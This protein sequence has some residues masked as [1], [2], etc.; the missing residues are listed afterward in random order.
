MPGVWDGS[1]VS[2][3]FELIVSIGSKVIYETNLTNPPLDFGPRNVMGTYNLPITAYSGS[4][5]PLDRVRWRVLTPLTSPDASMPVASLT[6]TPSVAQ[7]IAGMGSRAYQANVEIG[8]PRAGDYVATAAF[9]DDDDDNL[10]PNGLEASATFQV[11]VSVNASYGFD[12]LASDIDFGNIDAGAS[13]TAEVGFMNTGNAA[14][15]VA[16]LNWA[17]SDIA[18]LTEPANVIPSGNLTVLSY[19]YSP[20]PPGAMATATIRL[21]VPAGQTKDVYGPSGPQRMTRGA[22]EDSCTFRVKVGG[23]DQAMV[24]KHSLYQEIATLT[25]TAPVPPATDLYFLSAWVCPGSGSADVAFIQYDFTGKPVATVSLRIDAAGQLTTYS[26]GAFPIAHS[27]ISDSEPIEIDGD[28][29]RYYRVY[30]AF[31]LTFSEAV[32]S[33]TRLVLHNSSPVADR[34]VWFD[35]IKLERAFEGQTRPTTYHPDATLHSPTRQQSLQGGHQY[36]EW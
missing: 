31:N 4:N 18:S 11:R 7:A 22:I 13:K 30:L 26:A 27:G 19:S 32:A 23:S 21:S 36:Y 25:F 1:E 24:E 14:I 3:T 15:N 20:V 5:V 33:S 10:S 9:F 16:D 8:F 29:Y 35:G 6:F 17:F 28:E 12:I 2:D 34:R